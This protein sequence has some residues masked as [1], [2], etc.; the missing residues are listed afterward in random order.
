MNPL[1]DN[2]KSLIYEYDGNDYNKYLFNKVI[3]ELNLKRLN[4][5]IKYNIYIDNKYL[6][7]FQTKTSRIY[8]MDMLRNEDC[9]TY[10]D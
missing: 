8:I 5:F 6:C 7:S 4:D 3:Q 10:R 1:N 9:Y 2:I